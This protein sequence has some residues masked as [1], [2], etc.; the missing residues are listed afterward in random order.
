MKFVCVFILRQTLNKLSKL[1]NV[2]NEYLKA[3]YFTVLDR[4][5]KEINRTATARIYIEIKFTVCCTS[6]ICKKKR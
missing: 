1:L 4:R 3:A 6:T 2:F 5:N